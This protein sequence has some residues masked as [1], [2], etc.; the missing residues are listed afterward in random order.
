VSTPPK[1]TGSFS[2]MPSRAW[3]TRRE[4]GRRVKRRHTSIQFWLDMGT[5]ALE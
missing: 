3:R 2:S 5:L 1:P 4:G